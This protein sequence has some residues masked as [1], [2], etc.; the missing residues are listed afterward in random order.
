MNK[1][2][3]LEMVEPFLS[4]KNTLRKST[5]KNIFNDFSQLDLVEIVSVLEEN[6]IFVDITES[7]SSP[8]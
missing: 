5:F 7:I 6:R 1:H 2:V 4:E 8:N 3:I